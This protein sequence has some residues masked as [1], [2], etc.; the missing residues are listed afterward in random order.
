MAEDGRACYVYGVVMG[1]RA[2][3]S[4][5][6]LPAV[7]DPDAPVTLVRH[8]GQAAVVSEV[9]VD[10]PL[11][12][13][14][15]LRTHARVLDHLAAQGS[16][17]L[18]FRFG[19]VM[20][21]IAAVTDELLTEGHDDFARGLDRL[22]G[23]AQLTVRARYEQDAVLHEVV[24]EQPEARR[25]REELRGL[26]EE[27]GYEQRIELGRLVMDSIA[28]KRSVDALELDRRLAPYALASVSE[29]PASSEGL[30]NASFLV[31]DAKRQAF[32]EAAEQLAEHW[33]GR[34]RMRL[35]GPLAPYDFVADALL[36]GKEGDE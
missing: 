16:P 19:T 7:G 30:V 32:E 27:A 2:D 3:E 35:L 4:V 25:L 20:P 17:V 10:K 1:D 11:G 23:R 24:T 36:E 12:T 31:D 9:P 14:E 15:D 6:G 26:P 34:V 5:K 29:E 8:G 33:H 28:A 18:P 21:D 22:R 13:P